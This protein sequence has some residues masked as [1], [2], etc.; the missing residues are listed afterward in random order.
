MVGRGQ[1]A[2]D[3]DSLCNYVGWYQTLKRR[4]S[5]SCKASY[6]NALGYAF[7]APFDVNI[8]D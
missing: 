6:R 3:I 5:V 7:F 2:G 4:R 8:S 1:R